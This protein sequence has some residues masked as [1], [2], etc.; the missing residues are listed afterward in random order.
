M[1]GE[2]A[3]DVEAVDGRPP[4]EAVV[5]AEGLASAQVAP[6]RPIEAREPTSHRSP[7]PRRYTR[8]ERAEELALRDRQ[9][10][11]TVIACAGFLSAI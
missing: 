9:I 6:A 7:R 11:R 5:A 3:L 4:V 10:G 1:L 8:R 2:E